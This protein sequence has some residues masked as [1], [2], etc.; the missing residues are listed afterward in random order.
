MNTLT[1]PRK[2]TGKYNLLV[3]EKGSFERLTKE[4]AELR[5]AVKAVVAG[6][7]ALR[8]GRTRTFSAFLKDKFPRYAKD[9]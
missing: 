1:V 7:L 4:N 2:L 6:E 8:N 9:K 5:M 3:V